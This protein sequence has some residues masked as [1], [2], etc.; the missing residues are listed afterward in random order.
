MY[1]RGILTHGIFPVSMWSPD[2]IWLI[3]CQKSLA[4]ASTFPLMGGLVSHLFL[5]FSF[6]V[7]PSEKAVAGKCENSPVRVAFQAAVFQAEITGYREGSYV[8]PSGFKVAN[9]I[10]PVSVVFY[11]Q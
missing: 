6:I 9:N 8:N 2:E 5:S 11:K 10:S 7:C 4:P 1:V 3:P